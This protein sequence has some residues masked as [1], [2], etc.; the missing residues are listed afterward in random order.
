M[1]VGARVV[2]TVDTGLGPGPTETA[3]ALGAKLG[4]RFVADMQAA[5]AEADVALVSTADRLEL[6]VLDGPAGLV[7]GRGVCADLAAI[8]VTGP[9]GRRWQQPLLKACGVRKGQPRPRVVDATAGLGEDTW[10]LAAFGCTVTA[11]ERQP[12]IAA[13][14]HD[15]L[16]RAAAG[17]D[18]AATIAA[19]ITLT[20]ND[21]IHWLDAPAEAT[22]PDVVYLDPMFPDPTRRATQRKPMRVLRLIAGADQDAQALLA[23]ARRAAASRVVVKRSAKAPPLAAGRT[24][25]TGDTGDTGGA[26]PVAT[27]RG[28]GH[29]FD[30]YRPL[31]G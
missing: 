12:I 27:H 2:I 31:A 21:A 29:R 1:A 17:G 7:G 9:A 30:V 13:M 19:R 28:R 15:A 23:A 6:R 11:I 8:D 22:R 25:D 4:V 16:Q 26:A 3:R 14:L 10:V 18:Q 24:G 5:A 20:H